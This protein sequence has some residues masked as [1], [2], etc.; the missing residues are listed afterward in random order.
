MTWNAIQDSLADYH[1]GYEM[2]SLK[3]PVWSV[4]TRDH[5]SPVNT[6]LLCPPQRTRAGLLVKRWG[7]FVR[8]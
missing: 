2:V 3:I 8:L 5:R 1:S 4:Q 6:P 7:Q